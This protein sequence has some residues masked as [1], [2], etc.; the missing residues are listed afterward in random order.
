MQNDSGD[1]QWEITIQLKRDSDK[2]WR[3]GIKVYLS[4]IDQSQQFELLG[5]KHL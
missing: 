2:K 3:K 5:L 4:E 1:N